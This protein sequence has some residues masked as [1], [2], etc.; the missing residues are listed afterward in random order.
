MRNPP[1]FPS[2]RPEAARPAPPLLGRDCFA[3]RG[4]P[5]P[6]AGAVAALCHALLVDLRDDLAVTREQRFGGAHFGAQ[7]QL[8]RREP[9]GAV[10]LELLVR[11]VGFRTASAE[12]ALVHLAARAEVADA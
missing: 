2:R 11:A 3:I 5:A 10:L 7:R 6:C 9:V 12:G 8:A 4:L 1:R